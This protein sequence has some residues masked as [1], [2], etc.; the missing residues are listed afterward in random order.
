MR[1]FFILKSKDHFGY[2]E[3]NQNS[4]NVVAGGNE[5]SGR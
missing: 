2:R 1:G 3:V 5:W 4:A